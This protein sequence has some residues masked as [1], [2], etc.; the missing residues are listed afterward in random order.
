MTL[1]ALPA[2]RGAW[3]PT[4]LPGT[5][6]RGMNPR[7][8]RALWCRWFHRWRM[9]RRPAPPVTS[10]YPGAGA[11][12]RMTAGPHRSFCDACEDVNYY[13]RAARRWEAS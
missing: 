2:G 5:R 1:P 13:S 4:G 9:D 11:S 8:K 3:K 6:L 12:L 7:L 10:T